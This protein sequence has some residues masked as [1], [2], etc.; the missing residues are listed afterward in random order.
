MAIKVSTTTVIDDSLQLLNITDTD[1]TTSA[2]INNAI[3]DQNNVLRIYDST[4]TEIRTLH[5]A[6][7]TPAT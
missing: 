2:A 3:K 5:C 6:A 1:L 4:G 7:E